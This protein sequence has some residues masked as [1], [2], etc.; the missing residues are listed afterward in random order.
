MY[1]SCLYCG[2]FL[3]FTFTARWLK[4]W[5]HQPCHEVTIMSQI[6]K[7]MSQTPFS[8]VTPAGSVLLKPLLQKQAASSVCLCVII[9]RFVTCIVNRGSASEG[10]VPATGND[11][12]QNPRFYA[13]SPLITYWAAT[14]QPPL[15]ISNHGAQTTQIL[16][17]KKKTRPIGPQ[18]WVVLCAVVH[19]KGCSELLKV[20][21][22]AKK[23]L[24]NSSTQFA[25]ISHL[26]LFSFASWFM[27]RFYNTRSS[28]LNVDI[29]PQH[30]DNIKGKY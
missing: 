12:D 7:I 21:F 4:N 8:I 22:S 28:M 2:Y 1:A 16:A 14:E 24:N 19:F 25:E 26:C 18:S 17:A 9:Q 27:S 29:H 11:A 5:L 30:Q 10:R 23:R 20:V 6:V 15:L 3:R 13:P